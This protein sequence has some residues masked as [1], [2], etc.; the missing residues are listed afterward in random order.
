M[1]IS[2]GQN[3]LNKKK[4]FEYIVPPSPLKWGRNK[5]LDKFVFQGLAI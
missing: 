5:K 2:I 3:W 4:P 1:N